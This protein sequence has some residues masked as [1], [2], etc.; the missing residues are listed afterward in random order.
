MRNL[1][2]RPYLEGVAF[3]VRSDQV[4]LRWL[5]SFKDPSG[6]LARWR[7]RLADFYFIIQ[8]RPGIKNNL[9]DG[10]SRLP[11]EGSD[12]MDFDDDVP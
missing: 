6:R 3:T 4:A 9:A 8:Y 1:I 12:K 10:C 5:L 11:S 2:L 7:L